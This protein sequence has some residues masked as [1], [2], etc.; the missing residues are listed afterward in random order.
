MRFSPSFLR[1]ALPVGGPTENVELPAWAGSSGQ[2]SSLVYISD[3]DH[4]WWSFY[5][6]RVNIDSVRNGSTEDVETLCVLQCIGHEFGVPIWT[7]GKRI[8]DFLDDG[9]LF[10]MWKDA[11]GVLCGVACTLTSEHVLHSTDDA[12]VAA[13]GDSG[14]QVIAVPPLRGESS[15]LSLT[16]FT[17][18]V[19]SSN[20]VVY[21]IGGAPALPS[22]VYRWDTSSA[23]ACPP[24]PQ[25][26][27]VGEISLVKSSMSSMSVDDRY[28]SIPEEIA[29]PT[30]VRGTPMTAYGNYYAPRN[31]LFQAPEGTLPPLLVKLHGGPTNQASKVFRLDI[32]FFTSR[33]IAV[34]DVN[35][36]GSTGYGREYRE[37]LYGLW[38]VVDVDDCCMGAEYLAS[39]GLV[40]RD[41]LAIDGSSAGGFT[42]LAC[43][44]F[45]NTFKAATSLYGEESEWL[46]KI[47]HDDPNFSCYI[48]LVLVPYNVYNHN[49]D[50]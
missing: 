6:A 8:Y 15:S 16:A 45:R 44:T 30:V 24:N 17:Q 48:L 41:K 29:F 1:I 43:V 13:R 40:S 18:M 33:G 42:V 28:I 21:V 3:R 27:E 7:L 10:C 39:R 38:G 4:G 47:L 9:R 35:Y 26:A 5:H 12:H 34:L 46:L 22:G 49:D 50:F 37:R 25:A 20:G 36:G 23:F 11:K 2:T 31:P 32:Q 19:V 14:L